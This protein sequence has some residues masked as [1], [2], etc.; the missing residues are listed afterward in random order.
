MTTPAIS[1]SSSTASADLP[2]F[3]PVPALAEELTLPG[4][5][6]AA[7]VQLLAEGA[8]V[9][10]I[11]RYRKELTGGLDEVQIRAIEERRTYLIEMEAQRRT[12]LESIHA[13][14]K[15]TPELRNR[16]LACSTKAAL[17]DLYLPYKP[18]RRTRAMIARERGLEPLALSM[19]AQDQSVDPRTA[20]LAFVDI[21]KEVAD[22]D[23]AL[24]GARDIVAEIVA[25]NADVR[26]LARVAFVEEGVLAATVVADK[27]NERTK[28]EDYYDHTEAV[29][30]M[31]SHRYLAIRRGEKEGVIRAA[32]TVETERMLPRIERTM[33]VDAQ[34]PW[35]G[36]ICTAVADAWKR[37]LAPSVENDV[38]VDL[39]MK[40]DRDA[41]EVFAENLKHLLLAA[42]LGGKAV[43]GIDPGLRSG[44]KVAAVDATGKFLDTIVIFPSQGEGQAARGKRE[45]TAFLTK[46]KPMAIAVGN[47]TGG[48]EAETFT[49]EVVREAKMDGTI[50]VSVSEAG[51]SVYS[52]SDV[53]REEFPELDLTI[54]GAISIARRL[55]DPLAELVKVEPK[56]I[57]VGQ[58]QHDVHQP[59]LIRKLGEVIESC[60]NAVGVELN[61]AS[62]PLLSFVSGIGPAL[63]K[64]I[65]VHREEHGAFAT[66]DD[67]MKV[68]GLGPK[69]F[70]LAA[71]FLRVRG[72]KNPLDASAVHPERYALVERIAT[73]MGLPLASLVGDAARVDAIDVPSYVGK[74]AAEGV[75]EPTLRDI[76]AE[77]RK[78]GRDPRASFEPPKFRDDVQTLNDLKEGMVL[79]GVVTNVTAFGAFVD[80]GVHQDGLVHISQLSDRFIKDPREAVKVGD[81]LSVRV[82]EVD[83]VRQ[84]IALSAKSQDATHKV[85]G[86][87]GVRPA[88][89][90]QRGPG[91]T[92]GQAQRPQGQAQRPQ[93]QA[94]RPQ[95]Q[96]QS[97]GGR[98]EDRGG[99]GGE[100]Q[101]PTLA[102]KF[103]NNPFANL[104]P[105][106]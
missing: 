106:K 19:L 105:K 93:G 96:A 51:A 103:T 42:P 83:L 77:L 8:T 36:E 97:G 6:V 28:F 11:A 85:G 72:S 80:V 82:M 52:A 3:D 48:R 65:V 26:A 24:Q 94:Q 34:S 32:I 81:K 39:K 35:A 89:A 84:R 33:K 101:R 90:Q 16:I 53:A 62:A 38:R 2:T 25:E 46:Y 18:K 1:A 7:V 67:V 4:R 76:V 61:T 54:R 13:Q 95:G 86:A 9:P 98:P 27:K 50:V 30:K 78:P 43:V 21:A 47:G 44:C 56:A 71:G 68:P 92:Q 63:A 58:Y 37:L 15:L 60:V 20:A 49:R 66:R 64:K 41:V 31:P 45:L 70:V 69:A 79:E 12:V 57:G 91:Q 59:L 73:D 74:F 22:V 29:A 10:F 5:G 40:A 104:S 75:G 14:G 99:R 17:D 102:S 87:H 100:P 88:D 23:A 55:Q